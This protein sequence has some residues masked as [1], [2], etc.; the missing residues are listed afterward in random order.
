MELIY[1]A[2][3]LTFLQLILGVVNFFTIIGS[4]IFLIFIFVDWDEFD[5]MRNIKKLSILALIIFVL[6]NANYLM[7]WT[8]IYAEYYKV[9]NLELLEQYTEDYYIY[10][11]EY[12]LYKLVEKN[13]K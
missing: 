7:D 8:P 12:D 3:E 4:I 6:G 13:Q 2:S 9:D 1:F 5:R 11:G 10:N